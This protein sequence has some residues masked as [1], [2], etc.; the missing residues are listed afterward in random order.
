MK[1]TTR[2]ANYQD[3]LA[4][5]NLVVELAI[6]EEAED[7][8][9]A[10]IQDYQND[11]KDG[12]FECLV[13]CINDEVVGMMLYY[14]TYSTWRGRMLYL[15]DFVVKETHR[16][17]G[18]GQLLFNDFMKIADEKQVKLVKWQVLDWNTPAVQFYEKNKATIEKNWWNVK[19]FTDKDL[20]INNLK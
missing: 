17:K 10:T 19:I 11:F 14:M 4:I 2:K 20:I 15:E 6:Y 16:K 13:A 12:L 5:H 9:S 7:Q 8:V 1:I 3:L 18:F